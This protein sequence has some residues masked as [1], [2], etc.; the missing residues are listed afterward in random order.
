[1]TPAEVE[2]AEREFLDASVAVWR[3][4]DRLEAAGPYP[5]IAPTTDLRERERAA[6]ERYRCLLDSVMLNPARA[7]S[8]PLPE[9]CRPTM[10]L[11]EDERTGRPSLGGE[12]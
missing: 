10:N 2:Q 1:M 7:L 9:P 11:L 5:G 4:V 3:E 12:S 6:W 8:P